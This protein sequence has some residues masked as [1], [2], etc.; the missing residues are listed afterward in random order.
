MDEADLLAQRKGAAM[1]TINNSVGPDE[2]LLKEREVKG[3]VP[4]MDGIGYTVRL[5]CGH[6][7]WV[8]VKPGHVMRCGVCLDR[9]IKQIWDVQAH[10]EPA[11]R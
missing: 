8:G 7:I 10:Q 11:E 2:S 1:S 6:V 9:L 5:S 4:K 3:V